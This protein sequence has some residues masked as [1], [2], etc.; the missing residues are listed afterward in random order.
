MEHRLGPDA[1]AKLKGDAPDK[2]KESPDGDE[3]A[4]KML[5]SVITEAILVVD[6]VTRY[7]TY[8]N[9]A[10]CDMFGYDEG[11]FLQLRVE[12][13]HPEEELPG[14]RDEFQAM[15]AGKTDRAY[16]IP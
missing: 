6:T 5:F 10:A 14:V 4:Y 13:L 16:D 8:V 15:V 1:E 12:D 9:P 3:S 7:F 11:E 2:A